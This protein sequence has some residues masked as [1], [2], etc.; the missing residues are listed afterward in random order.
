[1]TIN[2]YTKK[3]ND[4][5]FGALRKDLEPVFGQTMTSAGI[6]A[7]KYVIEELKNEIDN[8][9]SGS[10]WPQSKKLRR[11][12]FPIFHQ[13]KNGYTLDIRSEL[14][15]AS[16]QNDGGTITAKRSRYLTIPLTKRARSLR[17]RDFPNLVFL[18]SKAGNKILAEVINKKAGRD[19]LGRRTKARTKIIPH[20]LLKT[21]VTIPAK[22]YIENTMQKTSPMVQKIISDALAEK[23]VGVT[24]NGNSV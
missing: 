6:F 8:S 23:F 9:T 22:N 21:S 13:T 16:I 5:I 15:Y 17:A 12:F 4:K 14:L 7:A 11:S 19:S 18:T 2:I 24:L 1:M 10:P 20:Y 3:F